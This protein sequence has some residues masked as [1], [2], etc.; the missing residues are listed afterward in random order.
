M[1]G[2][3]KN[4]LVIVKKKLPQVICSKA[5]L[6]PVKSNDD[7]EHRFSHAR[8]NNYCKDITDCGV[9]C[10]RSRCISINSDIGR[11]TLF[12]DGC[13]VPEYS[14]GEIE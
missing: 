8:D 3:P 9:G 13:V 14:S 7:C 6:C 2:K 1:S 4:S 10:G 5:L 12:V 11:A